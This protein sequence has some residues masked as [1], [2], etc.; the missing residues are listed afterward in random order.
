MELIKFRG[1]SY[2]NIQ[3]LATQEEE[4]NRSLRHANNGCLR[5]GRRGRFAE[6]CYAKTYSDGH[7]INDHCHRCG[8]AGHL[9]SD[10]FAATDLEGILI[11][12]APRRSS[13]ALS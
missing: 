8:R 9:A 6:S 5:C 12:Q 3:L 10:C 4:L 11:N 2:S 1:G 7:P 13:R